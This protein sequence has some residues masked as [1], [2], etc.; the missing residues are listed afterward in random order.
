MS[1]NVLLLGSGAREHTLAWSIAQSEL[2]AQ[3]YIAPGNPG[4]AQCGENVELSL[5]D[6]EGLLSFVEEKDI[7]LTVVGPEQ[8]LVGGITDFLE[9]EGHAVFGPSKY[10]AQLEG[11]KK[12]ANEFMRKNRIP[13]ADF[14][15]Y[16]RG[17]FSRALTDIK[18]KDE[19]PIVL[20]ANGLAGGKGVFVC[21]DAEEAEKRLQEL[22]QSSQFNDAAQTL[23]VEEFLD[24]EEV[25]VFVITDGKTAKIIHYAQ[26]HK[27]IGEAD[28]GLNTGGMGAYAPTPLISEEM[29]QRIEKEVVLPTIS[30]MLLDE[31]PYKGILYCGLMITSEGPEVVEFNCRFGDP[32]CQAIVPSLESDLL[33]LMQAATHEE[34]YKNNVEIDTKHRSCV[35]LAS[36]GYPG[37][38]EKGKK[39]SGLD[40]VSD[41]ALIFHA[42]TTENDGNI[43]TDGGRVLSIVGTGAT[44]Q[45]S[46][47][48]AYKEA[49]KIEFENKYCRTDIGAKGLAYQN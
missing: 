6:F 31:Q 45:D 42:G 49:D 23:V 4:T 26:D 10:A 7:D 46:I 3:L 5:S 2:L 8:P 35:V 1:L 36:G 18:Q 48:N 13:T 15:S 33:E 38:Y 32:E 17:E 9:S 28:T 37:V 16:K 14:K 27:R 30:A 44:L 12:F 39:I 22:G 47:Q 43:Y 40:E 19:Y 34:L 20:K 29:L 21:E 41:D 24:G 11:S 25:S